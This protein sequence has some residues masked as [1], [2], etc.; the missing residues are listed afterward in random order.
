MRYIGNKEKLIPII[1]RIMQKYIRLDSN[2]SFF[3][4][5]AGSASVGAYFKKEGFKV[6]SCDLLYFSYCL[7]R[8][9]LGDSNL[10]FKNLRIFNN[11]LFN[12]AYLNVLA[13][14]NTLR[15]TKG[16]IYRN[17]APSGSKET[18]ITRM[19]FSDK[20][21]KKIDSIRMQIEKWKSN[22]SENEY[23]LLLATLIES[24]SL[25]ANITGVYGAF[26]K[27]WDKRAL[28]D[29]ELK[30]LNL[31][32]GVLGECF[33]EDSFNALNNSGYYDI[34]YLDP[35]YNH[36][37]YAP[38]YHLLETIAKYDNPHIKGISGLRNYENQKSKFCNIKMVAN[39]LRKIINLKN[40]RYLVLS[41]NS[42][43]LLKKREIDDILQNIGSVYFEEIDY[44]RFKSQAKANQKYIKEYV[45][46][47][48]NKML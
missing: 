7:Q 17:Y 1:H 5:F 10:Q 35:P 31:I 15:G 20:N 42:E 28:K 12:D 25:Y 34:L 45:W 48:E 22:L 38:N 30:P 26:C 24:V 14:L 39:E 41:Y 4:V 16:F 27:Q 9:Y 11:N 21:A 32:D 29:F 40:Y 46:I 8:A 43:G 23:Y 44:L 36:R 19:Y 6:A 2:M 3:D 47:V 37:Q 13:Y 33:C 18:G